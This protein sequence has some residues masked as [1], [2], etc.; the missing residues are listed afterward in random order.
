MDVEVDVT[1]TLLTT[2][3]IIELKDGIWQNYDINE[4]ASTA[5]F[6]F[7]PKHEQHS[8]TIYYH[9]VNVD[10]K[11]AYALWKSDD[12][13]ISPGEW[14]F[15]YIKLENDEKTNESPLLYKPAR[16]IHI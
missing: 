2:D 15:P 9:S 16:F 7:L 3:V 10:I 12:T 5:H 8:V 11:I 6:Y 4:A 13:S 1:I 14:P